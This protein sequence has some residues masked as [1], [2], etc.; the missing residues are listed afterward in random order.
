MFT[1][2]EDN[3]IYGWVSLDSKEA[4]DAPILFQPDWPDGTPWASK[5]EAEFWATIWVES[6]NPDSTRAPGD[7]P[8]APIINRVI[9]KNILL[10]NGA[11][12]T[13][14]EHEKLLATGWFAGQPIP[15][16]II[17]ISQPAPAEEPALAE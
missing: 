14:E 6:L 5:K 15:E 13:K 16:D 10:P 9:S 17:L 2:N 7:S 12:I 4:G 8:S 1:I 11:E 3:S